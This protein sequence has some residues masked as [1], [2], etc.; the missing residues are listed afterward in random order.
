MYSSWNPAN[1][2]NTKLFPGMQNEL[3]SL[4]NK[5]FYEHGAV[6]QTALLPVF[7]LK[8]IRAQVLRRHHFSDI[9]ADDD[10]VLIISQSYLCC[11]IEAHHLDVN[12]YLGSW[13]HS[14]PKSYV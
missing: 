7:A 9:T 2:I 5:S 4:W 12:S 6:G 13:K 1:L 8:G 14:E 3:C 11:R 10:R